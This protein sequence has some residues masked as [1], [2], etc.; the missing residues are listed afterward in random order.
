MD[1]TLKA[2]CPIYPKDLI[3]IMELKAG[4]ALIAQVEGYRVRGH[5]YNFPKAGSVSKQS[6]RVCL[7]YV[8]TN[9]DWRP[10]P[11]LSSLAVTISIRTAMINGG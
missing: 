11:M 4:Q 6:I 8:Q 2:S 10:W 9:H 7:V 5:T 3:V 1:R